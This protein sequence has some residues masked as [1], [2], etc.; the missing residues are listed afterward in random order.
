M[1]RCIVLRHAPHEG[2]GTFNKPLVDAGFDIHS[3]DSWKSSFSV[4]EAVDAPLLVVMGGPMGV[5]EAATYPFLNTEIEAIRERLRRNRPILGV[6]LG[7][8]LIARA[9]GARVFPG[10]HFELGFA[11]IELTA[12]G[13]ASC[14]APLG[15]DP[16]VLHWHRDTFDLPHGATRLASSALYREQAFCMGSQVLALQFHLE[17]GGAGFEHW[18][19]AG[20]DDLRR[21]NVDADSLRELSGALGSRL[22]RKA[23]DVISRWLNDIV[24]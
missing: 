17:A 5:C 12:E 16:I 19:N 4:A 11:P 6:C 3:I 23:A 15:Q 7:A 1:K 9:A 14:L 20:A 18:I 10:E 21:A 22:E 13:S 8:Q 24:I 2:L